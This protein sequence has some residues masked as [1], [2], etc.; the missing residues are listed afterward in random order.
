MSASVHAA[1]VTYN[2]TASVYF[3]YSYDSTTPWPSTPGSITLSDGVI[4]LGDVYH[5]QFTYD[6]ATPL[7]TNPNDYDPTYT[8]VA[9]LNSSTAQFAS[10]VTFTSTP[11]AAKSN[12]DIYDNSTYLHDY[13]SILAYSGSGADERSMTFNF[14]NDNES[15]LNGKTIPGSLNAFERRFV[16]FSGNISPTSSYTVLANIDSLSPA[17]TAVPE[18]ETYA[19]LLAG[20]GL[21]GWSASKRKKAVA[22]N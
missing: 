12:I 16:Y 4:G 17:V 7:H 13:L 15:A 18:P 6:T 2:Y 3:I 11:G 22:A 9:P 1:T 14:A 10:G 19:M 8:G 20:I 5:G 21:V